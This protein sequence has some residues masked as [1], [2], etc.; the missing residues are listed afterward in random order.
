MNPPAQ[1]PVLSAN[2]LPLRPALAILT[3]LAAIALLLTA[4]GG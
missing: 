4:C 1:L 3:A 2:T